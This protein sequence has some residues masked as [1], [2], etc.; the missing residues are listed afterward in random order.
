MSIDKLYN[1]SEAATLLKISVKTL[2]NKLSSREITYV[3]GK[4]VLIPESAIKAYLQK[5]TKRALV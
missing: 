3:A 2:S 5:K 1:K 4:P